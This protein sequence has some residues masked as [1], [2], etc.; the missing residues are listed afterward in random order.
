[1]KALKG[2]VVSTKMQNP[3]VVEVTRR[4]PHPLYKKLMKRSKKYKVDSN[5]ITAKVGDSVAIEE[6]KPL[7]KDKHFKLVKIEKEGK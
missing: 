2:I 4:T 5:N 3:I 7:S 1:M 6:I